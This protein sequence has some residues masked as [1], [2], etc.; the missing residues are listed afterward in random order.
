MGYVLAIDQ[1]TTSTRAIAFDEAG[2]PVHTAALPLE[3]IYPAAG[4]VEHDPEEIW[5]AV[6]EVCRIVLSEVGAENIAAVGITNQRETTVVWDRATGKPLA[7]AIVWQD[8]R[9]APLCAELTREGWADHVTEATGLIIDPYFSAT[10]LAWLLEHVPGL[11]EA[12][13]RNEM[14]FGTI[15]SFLLFKLTNGMQHATD[16]TNAARTML[17]DIRKGTWD[18]ALLERLGIPH[19]ILPRVCDTQGDF[20][21][22]TLEDLGARLPIRAMVGD[23]QAAAKGQACVE[24]GMIKATYGTG[25]FVVAHTGDRQVTSQT[26]MLTTVLSQRDGARC[27]ALEGA[28]FMAG[29]TIQWLRDNLGLIA[30]AAE[31]EALAKT[32]NPDSGVYLVPA[33]QGLGAP[34]WDAK[35]RGAIVGLSRAANKA[36]IVA[37]G[38]EAMAFQ[39]RDLLEAMRPDMAV[40]GT[41]AAGALRV[42]GGMTANGWAMQRLA[43]ILGER[44]EVAPIPETTSL[45]A[46]L[47]AGQAVGF[48]GDDDALAG[49]WTPAAVY[50]PT[51]G[52]DEREHRYAGWLEAVD[53]VR[54]N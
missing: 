43:D 10:K 15:D 20:G 35:A 54:S 36:D 7:N 16:A 39:T 34:I 32:A 26:G 40:A 22:T 4:W 44:V 48:Y 42:D 25:C 5:N 11:A 30:D 38:L 49:A 23:Q 47:F 3:Q 8:R 17:F 6:R 37:A 1:G 50:E 52:M 53:R 45:G 12:A 21:Q 28:I 51:M 33:F 41:D 18:A 46:A 24:P 14:C 29:A 19:G 9:T 2:R 31:S 13:G 27:Y